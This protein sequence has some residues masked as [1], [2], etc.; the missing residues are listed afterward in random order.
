MVFKRYLVRV[1]Q[2]AVDSPD[3]LYIRCREC[4]TRPEG[5]I[6]NISNSKSPIFISYY[7]NPF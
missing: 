6:Y 7:Y 5:I 3:I 2:F 4:R 1:K